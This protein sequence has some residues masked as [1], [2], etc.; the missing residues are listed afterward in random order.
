MLRFA[1]LPLLAILAVSVSARA[2]FVESA[3]GFGIAGGDSMSYAAGFIDFD[4]DGDPDLYA[5]RHWKSAANL[6]RNDGPAGFIDVG[7]HYA[8]DEPDRHGQM[9]GDLDNDGDPDQYIVHGREQDSELFWNLGNGTFVEGA[10]AAGVVDREARGREPTFADFNRDGFLDIFTANTFRTGFPR[11]SR[12]Y[13]NQGD[14]TFAEDATNDILLRPREH[15]SSADFDNDGFVDIIATDP[16]YTEEGFY[17]NL[18][19]S[20]WLEAAQFIFWGIDPPLLEAQGISWADYD[21]DGNI[22]LLLCGGNRGVWDYVGLEGDSLRYYLESEPLETKRFTLTT[23][24][25]SVTIDAIRS[26]YQA[27]TCYFGAGGDSILV[28]PATFA[29]MEI[30]GEPPAL[31]AGNP[32]L[33]L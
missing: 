30:A 10:A 33:F 16:P 17:Y 24:G 22:D 28:F 32:G 14:G 9:W 5:N 15:A 11:P 21:N 2:E 26:D 1:L 27:V 23:D 7:G 25:D 19:D 18:G 8:G 31:S 29:I 6:Y 3:A 12:F 4:G 13:W 20:T